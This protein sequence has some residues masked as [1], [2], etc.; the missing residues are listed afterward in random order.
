MGFKGILSKIGKAAVG[1]TNEVKEHEVM[2]LFSSTL[3][4][5][6]RFLDNE[7]VKPLLGEDKFRSGI[8]FGI[9]CVLD[10]VKERGVLG[11]E[12]HGQILDKLETWHRKKKEGQES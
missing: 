11:E 9:S 12:T 3:E 6:D 8:A 2:E 7:M 10:G 4:R 5:I 1:L